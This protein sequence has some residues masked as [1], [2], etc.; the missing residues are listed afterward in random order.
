MQVLLLHDIR[1]VGKAMEIKNVSDGYARNFLFPRKL[2]VPAT[3]ENLALK[4]AQEARDAAALAKV[5]KT[6]QRLAAE[7]L[8]LP[9]RASEGGAV[10][11]SVTAGM[12]EQALAARGYQHVVVKLERPLKSVGAHEVTVSLGHGVTATA[13]VT[14]LAQ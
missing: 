3:K 9:V 10:F 14:L 5:Q 2:A 11:G 13:K 4:T 6:A 8:E 1:G 12:I 7:T